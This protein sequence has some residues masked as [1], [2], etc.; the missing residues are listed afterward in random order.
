MTSPRTIHVAANQTEQALH[1]FLRS[2]L[3]ESSANQVRGLIERRHVQLNGNLCLDAARPVK[4]GDVVKVLAHPAAAPPTPRDVRIRFLD[5]HLVVVEKP[6]GMTTMR[7][8]DEVSASGRRNRQAT[9]LDLLPALVAREAERNGEKRPAAARPLSRSR[10]RAN[11]RT[12]GAARALPP[13]RIFPVHRLDRDTSGLMVFART[14]EAERA[15]TDMFR[16]H[17][18]ERVYLAVAA[19][20]VEA[21]TIESHL[22]DDRG[23]GRRGSVADPASGKRAVTHV[24]PLEALAGYTLIECRLETGR[25][26]QIRIHLAERGHPLCGDRTYRQPLGARATAD[27]SGA[28]RLALHAAELRFS[29]PVTRRE[30]SFHARLPEELAGFVERLRR[31]RTRQG[32]TET[33]RHGVEEA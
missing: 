29:H 23:D 19:G 24:R 32:D 8:G 4:A 16:E 25:T 2:A 30:V 33:P 12:P 27:T 5:A 13:V 17:D 11:P 18:L 6:A 31:A 26:H 14:K 10:R 9:L 21:Q 15:L 28:P 22:A 3:P 1:A 20:T 7:Y